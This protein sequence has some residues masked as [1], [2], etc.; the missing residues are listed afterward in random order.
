MS[1]ERNGY[2]LAKPALRAIADHPQEPG[3]SGR[4]TEA[5]G[6]R[7]MWKHL[8]LHAAVGD[9]EALADQRD[10]FLQRTELAAGFAHRH[11]H[12]PARNQQVNAFGL[13]LHAGADG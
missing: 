7:H 1:F 10:G 4:G 13:A 2:A 5:V 9:A 12:A 11:F 3:S 8:D 6:A